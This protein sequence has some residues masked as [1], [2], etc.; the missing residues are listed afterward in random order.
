MGAEGIPEFIPP[1]AYHAGARLGV[2]GSGP[3][4]RA[5]TLYALTLFEA[6]ESLG[7]ADS[8]GDVAGATLVAV[9]ARP[10]G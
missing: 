1:S 10:D 3:A 4:G 5:A 9:G 6:E 2:V 8:A 7:E